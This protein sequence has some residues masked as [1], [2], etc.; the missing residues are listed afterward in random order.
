MAAPRSS[1]WGS[2]W[3]AG[4]AATAT[5]HPSHAVPAPLRLGERHLGV[6]VPQRMW[7]PPCPWAHRGT[8]QCPECQGTPQSR[9]TGA[10]APAVLSPAPCGARGAGS[11]VALAVGH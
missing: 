1:V 2:P 8:S 4:T 6:G 10:A 9:H 7:G 11:A 5:D 3:I